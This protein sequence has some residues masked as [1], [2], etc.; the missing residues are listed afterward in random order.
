[1]YLKIERM[2]Q[3]RIPVCAYAKQKQECPYTP[4]CPF[5]HSAFEA[6]SLNPQAFPSSKELYSKLPAPIAQPPITLSSSKPRSTRKVQT[7]CRH[8]ARG[9][10]RLGDACVFAHPAKRQSIPVKVEPTRSLGKTSRIPSGKRQICRHFERGFCRLGDACGFLHPA[11][12]ASEPK[13]RRREVIAP[14]YLSTL[15]NRIK[16]VVCRHWKKG[17]CML[18][19]S[20]QFRHPPRD[21][22]RDAMADGNSQNE[23]DNIEESLANESRAPLTEEE[24]QES[25]DQK[26]QF[27][28]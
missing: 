23:S 6:K 22:T 5:A 9:H 20:C 3:Q 1:V 28:L 27:N 19:V 21:A 25:L 26:E 17:Y 13:R 14:N 7:P 15:E 2:P 11:V 4:S 16:D 18:D 12:L 10:C 24:I 8:W